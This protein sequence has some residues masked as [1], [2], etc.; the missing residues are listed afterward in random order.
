MEQ[1]YI[2]F[3]SEANNLRAN[4]NLSENSPLNSSLNDLYN[5]FELTDNL[6]KEKLSES[7]HSINESR[8]K[9]KKDLFDKYPGS[10]TKFRSDIYYYVYNEENML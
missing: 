10:E 8:L 6:D 5:K 4:A 2:N 7:W 3:L 1:N 9:E